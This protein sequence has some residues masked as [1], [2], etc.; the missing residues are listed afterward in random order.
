MRFRPTPKAA[1][2]AFFLALAVFGCMHAEEELSAKRAAEDFHD[3]YD[4]SQ[5][6][7]LYAD[8]DL[9]FRRGEKA[10]QFIVRMK[11]QHDSLGGV[12]K[13]ELT[14]AAGEADGK[15]G[16]LVKQE[17]R[18]RFERG[19]ATERL[20]WRVKPTSTEAHLLSYRLR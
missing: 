16:V 7:A 9:G 10:S 6:G 15:G 14:G 12:V 17:F 8:T 2:A 3:R 4:K 19:T 5:F 13:A 1:L 11:A 18:T 20:T